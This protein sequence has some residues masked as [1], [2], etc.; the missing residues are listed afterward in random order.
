MPKPKPFKYGD[1]LTEQE[2]V[3]LRKRLIAGRR[4]P[5]TKFLA[6]LHSYLPQRL[7]FEVDRL[8]G[9]AFD[10]GEGGFSYTRVGGPS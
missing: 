6:A 2:A 8:R 4:V 3:A 10:I 9:L 5:L 1:P 7:E